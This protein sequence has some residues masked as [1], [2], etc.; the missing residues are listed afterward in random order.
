MPHFPH[1]YSNIVDQNLLL[2]SVFPIDFFNCWKDSL[3][4][5]IWDCPDF[6]PCLFQTVQIITL[7]RNILSQDGCLFFSSQRINPFIVF[8][9]ALARV[10]FASTTSYLH[11]LGWLTFVCFLYW[12]NFHLP[13]RAILSL[14]VFGSHSCVCLFAEPIFLDNVF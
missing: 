5:I 10:Y 14:F 8:G 11:L 6:V 1:A 2:F 9:F 12:L 7:S 13:W 4:N 3:V